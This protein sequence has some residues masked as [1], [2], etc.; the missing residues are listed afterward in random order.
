MVTMEKNMVMDLAF[1]PVRISR[2]AAILLNENIEKIFPLFGPFREAEWAE[3]WEPELLYGDEEVRE[4]IIFRTPGLFPGENFYLWV[5]SKYDADKPCIEYTVRSN[6]RIWFIMVECKPYKT[7]TLATVTYTYIGL[8]AE[9]HHQNQVAL[10]TIFSHNLTDWEDAINH[11]L[12][13]GK[14]LLS[15]S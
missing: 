8:S 2:S 6:E 10:E 15:N 3:G 1:A 5:I 7:F 11:Y 12:R 13:T 14:K 9:A 4:R